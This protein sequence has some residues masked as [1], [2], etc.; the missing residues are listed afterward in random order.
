M[1]LRDFG[2]AKRNVVANK[3]FPIIFLR[4]LFVGKDV[5]LKLASVG[6][7]IVQ[8]VR[9][10]VI[11][12]PLQLGLAVQMHHHFAS[13]FLID[14][15]NSHGFCASYNTV[16]KYGR[17]AAV[18]QGTD[19]PGY[20]PGRFVQ[21]V[22]DN[23]DHNSRT[24]DGTGT[25]HGMGIIATITPGTKTTTLIPKKDMT[26]EEIAAAGR[27][28]IRLYNGPNEDSPQL[29]YRELQSLRVKDATSNLDL[30]WKLTQPLLRSPRP[31]W[32]GTMQMICN[33]SYPVKSSVMF[34][35]MIDLDPITI[36]VESEALETQ[37]DQIDLEEREETTAE[38]PPMDKDL[39]LAGVLYKELMEDPS[40][41]DQVCS[42]DV[43]TTIAKKLE[44]K[45]GS[46]MSQRTAVLW[47]EYMKM[48]DILRKFIKAERTGNWNLH[49][50]AVYDMLPYF[51]AAGH[52]LYAKSAYIYL[53]LMYDLQQT[54]P[55]VYNSF[56]D[57]LHVVRRSDRFWAGLST[58]LIIEQVL[59]RSVKTTS[60]GLT[61]GR[62]M[63]E[64]Q[65]L[66]WLMS[67]PA[68]AD[69]NNAMQ[70]L[71]EIKYHTSEQHKDTTP[72]R[73]ERDHK[74]TNKI[75]GYL[76][77]RNPFSSDSTLRSIAT[78]II[79]DEGVNCDKSKEE[80]EKILRSMIGKNVHDHTFRRKDQ[81]VTLASKT[82]VQFSDGKVQ[83]DPQL[84]FQRLIIVATT[85]GRYNNPKS[86][87][88]YE[89]C[90]YP[91]ALFDASLLPRKANKPVLADA[92]WS[93][94][95]DSQ[96]AG[97]IGGAHFVLDGGALLHRVIWPRGLMYNA[98]CSLYVQYVERRYGKA[99]VV[100]D[101]YEDGPS[102]KDCTHQRRTS[103]CGP[104]VVFD[105]D[106]V[107][108]LK[109]DEFLSNK[110]NKQRFINLLADRLK[111]AECSILQATGDA[112]LLIVQTAIQATRSQTTVLVGDDTDL[113]VLLC[114]HGEMNA[115]D[116]YFKP[117]PK[118]RAKTRRV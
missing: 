55:E 15:L 84:L 117:E 14:S 46:M 94:T 17:S 37:N 77:Q 58:Y 39:E 116:L 99:T 20:I 114:Y 80:G 21:Y 106:M 56:L 85:S 79:A 29:S 88:Q 104:M 113:L 16:Q 65:R 4:T 5:S 41:S 45:K 36:G 82:A 69:V 10:R 2:A 51:A 19:I 75:I 38:L 109:K 9:P 12:A 24:L 115:N 54:H 76:S 61:R 68:C 93:T 32:S 96:T 78:G 28:D 102:T 98:I 6:Q 50:Q 7:T 62:R 27:I 8:A 90:S 18:T 30:L 47:M 67:M 112:D 26:A 97:P 74:D 83:I 107:I 70:N 118:Q 73:K 25:F 52:N 3:E 42:A 1:I 44:E 13:K 43:L 63:S 59:M 91:P 60:G 11:L 35:P 103:A 100:F 72:A 53:Q 48:V 108:T 31:A 95:R 71:T 87:F 22:A 34:L 105:P 66:V 33:G 111:Q 40:L 101:G 92:I 86:F 89:M 81:V 110:A 57:G 23:V 49:L 64:T